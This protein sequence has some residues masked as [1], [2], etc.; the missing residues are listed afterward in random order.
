MSR[1]ICAALVCVLGTTLPA[2]AIESTVGVEYEY[3]GILTSSSATGDAAFSGLFSVLLGE[4]TGDLYSLDSLSFTSGGLTLD[5]P[6]DS[7]L[8]MDYFELQSSGLPNFN[9]ESMVAAFYVEDLPGYG[10]VDLV[11]YVNSPLDGF[12][13]SDLGRAAFDGTSLSQPQNPLT[14]HGNPEPP[15]FASGILGL[16]MITMTGRRRRKR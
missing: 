1:I 7:N 5:Y 15:A 16:L 6:T 2:Y 8:V 11:M 12:V 4:S 14:F 10:K 9:I 13:R 3:Q